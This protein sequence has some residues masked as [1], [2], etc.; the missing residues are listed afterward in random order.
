MVNYILNYNFLFFCC[1]AVLIFTSIIIFLI[2]KN[3]VIDALKNTPFKYKIANLF[4]D[5]H[6]NCEETL[7]YCF[8]NGDCNTK[9]ANKNYSCLTG[10][11]RPS[12][13][14]IVE[15][16]KCIASQGMLA[17]LVGNPA[18]GIYDFVC[19]SVDPGIAISNTVNKMC[20]PENFQFDYLERFPQ[21]DSCECPDKVYVPATAEKRA[22]VEC[23]P[24]FKDLIEY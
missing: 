2:Y 3:E 11:C 22:H 20:Y 17:Y 5:R 8:D 12:L 14:E 19:K 21:I 10:V 6:L 18:F 4:V 24:I 13:D 15:S 16:D 23:S 9:C 7:T 1:I